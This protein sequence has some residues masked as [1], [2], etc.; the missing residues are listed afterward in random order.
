MASCKTCKYWSP[1]S[2]D[3]Y[4]AIARAG[5]PVEGMCS[6]I[7]T[8]ELS[9]LAYIDF[10]VRAPSGYIDNVVSHATLVTRSDFGCA[11]WESV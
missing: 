11:L 10:Y 5:E 7:S 4:D 2:G 3:A 8:L 6:Q 1:R 9:D